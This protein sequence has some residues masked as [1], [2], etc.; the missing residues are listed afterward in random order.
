MAARTNVD[1]SVRDED[2]F[3]LEDEDEDEDYDLETDQDTLPKAPEAGLKLSEEVGGLE[4][5]ESKSPS[6]LQ[7]AG[8]PSGGGRSMPFKYFIR[9]E[10]TLIGLSLKLGVDGRVLCRLNNLPASTLRTTPHL[11]HTRSYLIL[12]P[13]ASTP[14]LTATEQALDDERRA[15][16]AVERAHTRFQSMTKETNRDV[17]KA[18][19]AL[20]SLPDDDLPMTGDVKEYDKDKGLGERKTYMP[21]AGLGESS[22]EGRAVD[23]YFDDD[24][25]EARE[26]AEGRKVTIPSFPLFGRAAEKQPAEEQKPWWRWRN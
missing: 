4:A 20:A 6:T 26:R 8:Q 2:V 18:Y 16:I 21:E 1:G 11:L 9:P 12:P 17:A 22:L 14:P 23:R 10:D 13:S 5:D 19:V 3:V 15:R 25:W 7:E 24:E